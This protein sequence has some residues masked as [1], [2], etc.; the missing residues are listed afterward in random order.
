MVIGKS[1]LELLLAVLSV[2]S[3]FTL[4]APASAHANEK[5]GSSA[6]IGRSVVEDGDCEP[7][8]VWYSPVKGT[9]LFACKNEEIL[10]RTKP[11]VILVYGINALAGDG[12][13]DPGEIKEVTCF[14]AKP[15]YY[16]RMLVRMGYVPVLLRGDVLDYLKEAAE[17]LKN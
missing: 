1:I 7:L 4:L 15:S 13:R 9:V 17:C 12:F 2:L 16:R 14:N 6:V 5:H 11:W 8:E 3:S 10:G